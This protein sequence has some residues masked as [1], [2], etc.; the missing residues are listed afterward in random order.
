MATT[1]PYIARESRAEELVGAARI[2]AGNSLAPLADLPDSIP[3]RREPVEPVRGRCVCLFSDQG[4]ARHGNN[5]RRRGALDAPRCEEPHRLGSAGS[6][7]FRRLQNLLRPHHRCSGQRRH[8]GHA[9]C[10]SGRSWFLDHLEPPRARPVGSRRKEPYEKRRHG[11][12]S[13]RFSI[14]GTANRRVV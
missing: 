10:A 6:R 9:S 5:W 4:P 13:I 2:V 11:D 7:L 3:H 8:G 1:R 12:S 14:G